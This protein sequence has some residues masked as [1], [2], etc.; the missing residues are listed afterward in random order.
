MAVYARHSPGFERPEAVQGEVAKRHVFISHV[1]EDASA[2]R[3][4][5]AELGAGGVETWL[6]RDQLPPGAWWE[7]AIRESIEGGMFF[8]ACFS[9]RSAVRER[10]YM[11]EELVIAIE[12]LRKRPRDRAWFIPV[13]L[14]PGSLPKL[15]I[16]A[17]KTLHSI[18]YVELY[19]DWEQGVGRLLAA[20][21][22]HAQEPEASAGDPP[23]GRGERPASATSLPR[24]AI[25][26][27][28]IDATVN[29]A[30]YVVARDE[31]L[32]HVKRGQLVPAR[33]LYS[34]DSGANNWLRLCEDPSS[35]HYHEAVEFWAGRAG[36]QLADGIRNELGR[37][38]FNYVSLGCGDGLKD[39]YLLRH[40]LGAKADIIYSP[41]DT[42]LPLLSRASR[43][44][45]DEVASRARGRLYINALLADF[46]QLSPTSGVFR[47]R[48][49]PNVVALLGNS[50][51]NLEEEPKLLRTVRD[52]LSSEDLLVLEVRLN[53]G[54][55]SCDEGVASRELAFYFGALHDLGVSLDSGRMT[56]NA[57][58]NVSKIP[59][60]VTY[61]VGYSGLELDGLSY[62]EVTLANIHLYA[63]EEF[64]RTLEQVGFEIVATRY[65]GWDDGF[66]VCV[67][68][69]RA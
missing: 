45:L 61:V 44:V 37:D 24:Q 2:V 10:S 57:A 1:R 38:D 18:Q 58:Q 41:Y 35:R 22:P 66:L 20:I 19:G 46:N 39:A 54:E 47:Q 43:R 63:P 68:R 17:G 16:G 11:N 8:I 64:R 5:A 56:C 26:E 59:G 65:G 21:N 30:D 28:F 60:T 7:A 14:S 51:G 4:L 29:V 6:A 31:I 55:R 12:E 15:D 53:S 69:R 13:L 67:A 3:R 49:S 25:S 23:S 42:S 50:L 40:W 27:T 36:K 9:E 62:A 48:A 52:R 32:R 33:F 34:S